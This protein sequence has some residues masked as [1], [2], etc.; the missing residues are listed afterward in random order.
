[1]GPIEIFKVRNLTDGPAI[2]LPSNAKGKYQ[3][4]PFENGMILLDPICRPR[5]D[6]MDDAET[7]ARVKFNDLFE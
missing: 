2:R 7:I 5:K 1:M 6:A 3:V 4:I